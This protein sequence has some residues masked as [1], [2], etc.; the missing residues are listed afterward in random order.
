[1]LKK[2]A[3]VLHFFLFPKNYEP[4]LKQHEQLL[5]L[6]NRKHLLKCKETP[7][8]KKKIFSNLNLVPFLF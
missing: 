3:I 7:F 4:Y 1:M 2:Q 8:K 6:D 5:R